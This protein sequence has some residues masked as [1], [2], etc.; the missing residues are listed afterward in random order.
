M[1]QSILTIP[2]EEGVSTMGHGKLALH[3]S[4]GRI[5]GLHPTGTGSGKICGMGEVEMGGGGK[6][7]AG[8][9]WG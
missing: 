8:Q 1:P 7:Q 2:R 5:A 6:E 4:T 9:G 3:L